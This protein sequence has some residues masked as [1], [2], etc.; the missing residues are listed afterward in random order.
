MHVIRVAGR[1]EHDADVR[2]I[3][4]LDA[5]AGG[6]AVAGR[7]HQQFGEI[8]AQPRQQHLRLGIAEAD[9]ELDDL[10]AVGRQHQADVEEA[11]ERRAVG[12]HRVDHRIDD[13]VHHPRLEV[14]R[15]QRARREGAHAA[16]VRPAIVVEGPLVILRR[17]QRDGPVAV[18][19]GEER[20]FGPLQ[21]LLDHQRPPGV[22]DLAVHHQRLDGGERVLGLLG[23]DD[24]LAAGQAVGLQRHRAA[25]LFHGGDRLL[26]GLGDAV[27]GGRH[28]GQPHQVLRERLAGLQP[29]RLAGRSEQHKSFRRK[30]IRETALERRLGADDGQVD[31]PRTGPDRPARRC[32]SPKRGRPAPAGPSPGCRAP[33]PPRTRR[34]PAGASTPARARARL[35]PPR[36]PS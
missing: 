16:R 21:A 4:G 9:V 35:R 10:G 13:L 8:D 25:Q 19:D 15:E 2:L 33:S 7:R 1:R 22:A 6:N 31:A 26:R 23:D 17:R 5:V 27:A 18:G 29:G 14:A 12:L 3:A 20:H 24:A 32:P 11:A 30:G 34:I 28:A 36:G